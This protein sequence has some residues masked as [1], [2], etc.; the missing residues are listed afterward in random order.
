MRR[1]V[2]SNLPLHLGLGENEIGDFVTK[3]IIEKYLNDERN[4]HPVREVELEA[5]KNSAIVELSSVEEAARLAKVGSKF[6]DM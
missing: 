6:Y 5:T 4:F 2:I 3:F 1:L